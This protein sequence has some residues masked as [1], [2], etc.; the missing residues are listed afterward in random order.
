MPGRPIA[1]LRDTQAIGTDDPASLAVWQAH[2]D[3]MAA[4]AARRS[5]SQPDLRLSS[6]D[7][8]SLALCRADRLRHGAALRVVLAVASVAGLAPGAAEAM[9]GGPSW[10]GW[11]QPPAYT[12]KPSLYLNDITAPTLELPTGTRLQIRLYGAEGELTVDP[13][14]RRSPPPHPPPAGDRRPPPPPPSRRHG[15]ASMT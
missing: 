8:F 7:P 1:A 9:P 13:D 5:P 14:R 6:R 4:R 10:E 2:Q 15:R 11:A 3:R 12:G